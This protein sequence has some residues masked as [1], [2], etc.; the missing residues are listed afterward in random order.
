MDYLLR[1]SYYG[2]E[3]RTFDLDKIEE[4]LHLRPPG[5]SGETFLG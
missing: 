5:D 4:P 1:D 2:S 3:I